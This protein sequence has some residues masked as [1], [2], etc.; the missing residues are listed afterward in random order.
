MISKPSASCS[1]VMHSGGLVWIELLIDHRVQPVVAEELADRL[2]LV[3]GAVERGDRC[4][5]VAAPDEV[6]DPEQAEVAGRADARVPGR[7]PLVVVA[8]DRTQPRGVLD[9]AILLVD[10]DRREGGGQ[11]DRVAAVG[12][13]A[14]VEHRV[15]NFSATWWFIATAPSG[16]YELV[17]PLAIVMRSGVTPQ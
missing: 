15:S 7:Q 9:E 5:R 2:H 13:P 17:R 4:P 10:A 14:R 11:A 12:Q 8:H 6:Q 16:R 1:S 3:G